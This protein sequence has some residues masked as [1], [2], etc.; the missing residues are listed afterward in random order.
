ML[1]DS[2]KHAKALFHQLLLSVSYLRKWEAYRMAVA[3]Q[4]ESP[5]FP[6]PPPPS[7]FLCVLSH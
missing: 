2:A 4:V 1:Q 7:L 3:A 6:S 5:S